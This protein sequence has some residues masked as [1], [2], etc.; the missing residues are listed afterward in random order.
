[1]SNG[2]AAVLLAKLA[3]QHRLPGTSM[4]PMFAEAGGLLSYGPDLAE[5]S[6]RCAVL[7]A[8]I[9]SGAKPGELPIE[10]PTKLPLLLNLKTAK[11]LSLAVPDS[12][13]IR[14]DKVI[15]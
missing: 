14:A 15:R 13:V 9:L 1:M 2:V 4:A 5:A 11:A 8:K 3:N 10:R 6:E 7:V 12:V